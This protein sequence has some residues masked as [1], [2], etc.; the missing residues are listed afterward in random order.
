MAKES[1]KRDGD[2]PSKDAASAYEESI[3]SAVL[4]SY[5]PPDM[6][7]CSF[8]VIHPSGVTEDIKFADDLVAKVVLAICGEA[9]TEAQREYRQH[10][11]MVGKIE[12]LKAPVAVS[13]F[14]HCACY[15]TTETRM[16]VNDIATDLRDA[17][18]NFTW[19]SIHG[20]VVLIRDFDAL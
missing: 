12:L 16:P 19:A 17:Y 6:G 7:I 2:G 4:A 18:D 1:I 3:K 8:R 5:V 15:L 10:R 11:K 20:P 14:V 9:K 13:M